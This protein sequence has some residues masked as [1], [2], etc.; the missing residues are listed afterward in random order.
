[1]AAAVVVIV[2]AVLAIYGRPWTLGQEGR[3]VASEGSLY[4]QR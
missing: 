4:A 1:M 2:I 3:G